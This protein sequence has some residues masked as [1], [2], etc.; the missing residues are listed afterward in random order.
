MADVPVVES[1][2]VYKAVT[3]SYVPVTKTAMTAEKEV[4]WSAGDQVAV[5]QGNWSYDV[6]EVTS[7]SVG[8]SEAGFTLKTER[9][10]H[11]QTLPYNVAV[12]PV[13]EDLEGFYDDE[14]SWGVWGLELPSTQNYASGSFGNGA[15]PMVAVSA[16]RMF[17]FKNLLGAM[18]LQLKGDR[19]VKSITVTDNAGNQLAGIGGVYLTADDVPAFEFQRTWG[20]SVPNS[21]TLD[22]GEGVELNTTTATEFVIALPETAF[23]EGFTVVLVDTEGSVLKFDSKASAKN[24]IERSRVLVM[25]ELNVESLTQE[26]EFKAVPSITDAELDIELNV[27]GADGF[28]GFAV[29][30]EMWDSLKESMAYGWPTMNDVLVNTFFNEGIAVTK[31]TDGYHGSLVNYGIPAELIG[32]SIVDVYPNTKYYIAIVPASAEKDA[33][34]GMGGESD[35]ELGGPMPLMD[36]DEEES[37]ASGYTLDDLIVYELTTAGY[38][39]GAN[40][41]EPE[42]EIELDYRDATITV[43]PSTEVVAALYGVYAEGE[44]LPT[45]EN[46]IE[47]LTIDTDYL[48]EDGYFQIEIGNDTG[49]HAGSKHTVCLLLA[50]AEGKTSFYSVEVSLKEIPVEGS[51]TVEDYGFE[52]LDTAEDL[53]DDYLYVDITYPENAA[54]IYYL[55]AASHPCPSYYGEDYVQYYKECSERNCRR[56]YLY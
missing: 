1:N 46:Y 26:V 31:Y 22:C 36:L 42:Y 32:E 23:E 21:V 5:F 2:V 39:K 18:K 20:G 17:E 33:T 38:T 53:D 12:Y 37:T 16:D 25:P 34:L 40:L 47:M 6:F 54:K 28:Y 27:D 14:E 8:K 30:A 3:E 44:E 11:M 41:P 52:G 19:T 13:T 4:V 50:D 48:P 10:D 43:T 56:L 51:I 49:I 9:E 15:F 24:Y 29:K 35:D 55:L 45:E 7:A